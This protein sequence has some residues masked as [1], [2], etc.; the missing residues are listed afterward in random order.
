MSFPDARTL[1]PDRRAQ[2][3]WRA[4]QAPDIQLPDLAL[5]N[6]A[7]CR[8]H[9]ALD[10]GCQHCG[11][12]LRR[13]QRVGVA[14]LYWAGSGLLADSV[15]LGKTAQVAGVIAMCKQAGEVGS[16]GRVVVIA[17]AAAVPQWAEELR[18]FVPSLAVSAATG[19]R[20]KRIN[21]YLADW[22]VMVISPQTLISQDGKDL[23]YLLEFPVAMVVYDD[24]DAMRHHQN[25]TTHAVK[26]LAERAGRVIGV[27]GTPLQKRL[28]ELHSF[29]E[30][31][32][33]RAAFG[34]L[35][36][37]KRRYVATEPVYIWVKA[38]DE[39]QALIARYR[40]L[41]KT[42]ATREQATQ[43]MRAENRL[44][45]RWGPDDVARLETANRTGRAVQRKVLKDVG[46]REG[47]LPEFRALLAPLVLRRTADDVDDVELP[48]IQMNT[49]WLDPSPQQKARYADL[50]KGVLTRLK[51]GQESVTRSEAVAK[52]MHGWQICSGLATLDE[53][54]DDSSKLDWTMDRLTG[55]LDGDKVVVFIN[56]K[57]NVAALASRLAREG[58]GHVLLWG[59]E[60][61]SAERHQ[62]LTRFRSD[63]A[64]RVLIGTTT[65]EQS[66]NLQAARHLI[67]VDTILNPARMMQ[68]AGRIRRTGSAYKTVY[69]HQLLLRGTQEDGYRALLEREQA[70]ADAVW[71]DKSELF[72]AVSPVQLMQLV[73]GDIQALAAVPVS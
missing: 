39:E 70:L 31:V 54:R 36:Q 57:P 61:S 60:Q 32:G 66:L 47:V 19:T 17:R 13:H 6:T 37:F 68:L 27:H 41:R 48:A 35:T 5:F 59:N 72:G 14:W 16:H 28:P 24:T 33:G 43:A 29:L 50:R 23:E 12:R 64:C 40:E 9:D 22:E 58:I 69:V 45:A 4:H 38:S 42:G 65:I 67:A 25:R 1:D 20:K 15:G 46:L 3:A 53:G 7:P 11:I 55:D 62:R 44:P 52:F 63:P 71:D 30:P 49:V 73:A 18:R 26:K 2:I 34:S 21:A 56:F 51:D 10:P 8:L